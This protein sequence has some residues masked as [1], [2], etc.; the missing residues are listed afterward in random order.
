MLNADGSNDHY[1]GVARVAL[2]PRC[3]GFL[4]N[5]N[6]RA[7]SPAYVVTAGHCLDLL[8]TNDVVVDR[9]ARGTVTFHYFADTADRRKTVPVRLV[10]YATMKERDIAILELEAGFGELVTS[11]VRPS[12]LVTQ[13][14]VLGALL[15]AV[16]APTNGVPETEQ[17]LRSSE[18]TYDGPAHLLELGWVFLDNLRFGC[19]GIGGG[20]SGSPLFDVASGRVAG[21]IHTTTLGSVPLTDCFLNRPCE[22]HPGMETSAESTSYAVT[23]HELAHCFD[24]VGVFSRAQPGCP[25]DPGSPLQVNARPVR[26][27]RATVNG[28]RV[29]WSVRPSGAGLERVRYKTGLVDRTD[30]RDQSGYSEWID[31]GSSAEIRE[32]VPDREGRYFFCVLGQT[33]P[34]RPAWHVLKVDMTPPLVEPRVVIRD[35]GTVW[36][37]AVSYLPPELSL[38]RYKSG[39][40]ADTSCEDL[41]GYR[42]L[43]IGW[44]NLAKADAPHRLCL[45]GYDDADN[46]TPPRDILV[47]EGPGR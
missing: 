41:E 9:V 30:C 10:R 20:S 45:I 37:A 22:I 2:G 26:S 16:G 11:G 43:L 7:D 6:S 29:V 40:P 46:P 34:T 17:F 21:V 27:T 44:V 19:P 8:S 31:L 4:V 32:L 3:T 25:L 35:T 28:E 39:R 23:V 33:N 13:P 18:C 15:G 12:E 14:P 42:T 24:S 36:R 1:T 38:Y 47:P 5:V